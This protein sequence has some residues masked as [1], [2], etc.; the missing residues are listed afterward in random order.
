MSQPETQPRHAGLAR[1]LADTRAFSETLCEPLTAEDM[2]LQACPE[3]SPPRWHLA[4]TT[5]FFETFILKPFAPGYKPSD[6]RF[7]YLFNSY[8]NGVGEQYPRPQRHL[9]SRPG[10]EAVRAW[11]ASVDE[12]MQALLNR[13]EVADE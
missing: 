10:N 1:R 13:P 11:R 8:Y 12:A 4:H 2:G 6:E 5:W 3:V 9:L 7:E